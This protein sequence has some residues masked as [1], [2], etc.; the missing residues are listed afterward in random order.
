MQNSPK[1]ISV[2][3]VDD[4]LLFA[5]GMKILID[6]SE[7]ATITHIYKDI[8]SCLNGLATDGCPDV[9][10]LDINLPDGTGI[11]FCAELKTLYP[12][13]KVVMLTMQNEIIIV[14][15]S[16]ANGALGY[17]LK[18]SN[19][20]EVIKCIEMV[21]IGETYI[22]ESIALKLN[23][24]E[25]EEE[26]VRLSTREK[27]VLQLIAEGLSDKKIADKIFLSYHRVRELRQILLQKFNVHT[28]VELVEKAKKQKY[29]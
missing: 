2:A 16:L 15:R 8:Q 21:S 7:I 27:Q 23:T 4:H 28:A 14:K 13:L 25:G 11:D 19:S 9:L 10:L 6:N 26:I 18:D 24:V 29:I 17:L 20:K 3:I 1:L 22:C 5:E 12:N